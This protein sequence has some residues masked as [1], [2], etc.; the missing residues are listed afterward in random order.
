MKDRRVAFHETTCI[1]LGPAA[2]SAV[3]PRLSDLIRMHET[4]SLLN[5][6]DSDVWLF[7]KTKDLA[8]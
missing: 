2:S 4:R 3:E 7:S 1:G 8:S 5:V 6:Y